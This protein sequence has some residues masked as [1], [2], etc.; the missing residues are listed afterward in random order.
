MTLL[1]IYATEMKTRVRAKAVHSSMFPA[2]LFFV[3]KRWPQTPYPA[4]GRRGRGSPSSGAEG[5]RRPREAPHCVI[6]LLGYSQND[7]LTEANGRLAAGWRR[8]VAPNRA[9]PGACDGAA[10]PRVSVAAVIRTLT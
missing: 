2:V 9:P 10:A 3:A 5:K 1:R 6:P 8:G 4:A 7:T